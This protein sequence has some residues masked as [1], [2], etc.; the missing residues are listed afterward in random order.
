MRWIFLFMGIVGPLSVWLDTKIAK[1][2]T[3]LDIIGDV[4]FSA[5]ALILFAA[6]SQA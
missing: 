1:Y 5:G 2:N 4:L 3:P 6:R